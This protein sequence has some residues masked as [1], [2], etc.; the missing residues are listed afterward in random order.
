MEKLQVLAEGVRLPKPRNRRTPL[1]VG[2]SYERHVFAGAHGLPLEAWLVPASS[3][4]GVV[5][6]FHGHAASKDQLLR[7]AQ[8]FH[9]MGY[10]ALLV[11]FYGSGGSGGSDTSIGFFEAVDVGAAYRYA[12]SLGRGRPVILYGVSMGAAA[13]LKAVYDEQLEPAAIV[14]ECPFDRLSTTAAHRFQNVGLPAFPAALLLFWGGVQQGFNPFR[15][16]PV[17]FATAVRSPTLLMQGDRDPTITMDEARSIFAHLAGPKTLA[18]FP[19]ARHELYIGAD[20]H[21]WTNAVGR[22]FGERYW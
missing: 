13:I 18:I 5:V 17:E 15:M 7:V 19:G 4:H 12:Q 22:F 2:L 3:D 10:A 20:R 11:D 8:A 1:D 14:L 6:L 21:R 9:Q 16:N